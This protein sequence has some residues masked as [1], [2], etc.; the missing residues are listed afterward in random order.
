MREEYKNLS[1]KEATKLYKIGEITYEELLIIR[2][3]RSKEYNREYQ[4]KYQKEYIK[5]HREQRN[6]T[7]RKY[8]HNHREECLAARKKKRDEKKF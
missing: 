7:C 1:R 3:L 8:Y 2:D 4:K 6:A 5:T